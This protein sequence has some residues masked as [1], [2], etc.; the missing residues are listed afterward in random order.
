MIKTFDT[1]IVETK[2]GGSSIL[3]WILGFSA[4]AWLAYE[5]VYK[6]SLAKDKTDS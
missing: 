4:A 2:K 5:Y 3:L 1:S 6:P